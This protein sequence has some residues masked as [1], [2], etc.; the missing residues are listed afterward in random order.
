[1]ITDHDHPF[2]SVLTHAK[3]GVLELQ[4]TQIPTIIAVKNPEDTF[5]LIPR[6]HK[7]VVMPGHEFD[8][9]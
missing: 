8:E 1:M 5:E 7:R 6:C 4:P 9:L 3:Q 2:Y